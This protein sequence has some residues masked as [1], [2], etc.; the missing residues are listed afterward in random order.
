MAELLTYD[1][2]F[3]LPIEFGVPEGDRLR[4]RTVRY[5][6]DQAIKAFLLNHK[7]SFV[8]LRGNSKKRAGRALHH[9]KKLLQQQLAEVKA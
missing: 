7:I 6:V 4:K 2:I 1:L 8:E 9:V 3:Y 5:T